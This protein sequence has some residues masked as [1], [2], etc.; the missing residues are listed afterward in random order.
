MRGAGK[1]EGKRI[2]NKAEIVESSK[3]S[4]HKVEEI[5]YVLL[6]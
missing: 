5:I 1:H 2:K 6:K 3:E 4:V